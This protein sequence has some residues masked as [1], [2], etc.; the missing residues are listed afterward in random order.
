MK[1]LLDAEMGKV[2]DTVIDEALKGGG[3]RALGAVQTILANAKVMPSE[4]PAEEIKPE[5]EQ[6]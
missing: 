6:C 1:L 4:K 2:L 3:T 5:E